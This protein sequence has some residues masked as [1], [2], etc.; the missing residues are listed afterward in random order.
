MS[1]P[2]VEHHIAEFHG[3]ALDLEQMRHAGRNLQEVAAAHGDAG[4]AGDRVAANLAG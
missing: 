3:R 4:A 1:L 2:G